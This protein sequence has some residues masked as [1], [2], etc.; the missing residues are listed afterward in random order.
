M[1]VA[2]ALPIEIDGVSGQNLHNSAEWGADMNEISIWSRDMLHLSP[3][4]GHLSYQLV[5]SVVSTHQL[6]NAA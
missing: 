5:L 3:P 1:I 4:L 6:Q 2:F